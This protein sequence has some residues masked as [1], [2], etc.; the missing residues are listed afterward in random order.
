MNLMRFNPYLASETLLGPSLA[1]LSLFELPNEVSAL[2]HECERDPDF[3]KTGQ[4]SI[5]SGKEMI[6]MKDCGYDEDE[7]EDEGEGEGE[8]EDEDEDEDWTGYDTYF[9]NT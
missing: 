8:D 9:T 4:D 7:D 2:A 6:R 1:R 3:D 5:G